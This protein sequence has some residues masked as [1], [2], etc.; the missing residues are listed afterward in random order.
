ME[1]AER[2]NQIQLASVKSSMVYLQ[3][4]SSSSA[5]DSL[6]LYTCGKGLRLGSD[7]TP[8]RPVGVLRRRLR[9]QSA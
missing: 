3:S 5:F 8:I 4:S 7:T 6:L 1:C 9:E 2:L